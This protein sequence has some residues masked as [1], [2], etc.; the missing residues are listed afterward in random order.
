MSIDIEQIKTSIQHGFGVG[1]T[2]M[3]SLTL[4][5]LP[6]SVMMNRFIHHHWSLRLLMG[7]LGSTM[8]IFTI[9]YAL[10]YWRGQH[11]FGVY[12]LVNT[13][14]MDLPVLPESMWGWP[15]WMFT[16]M[17]ML[18]KFPLYAVSMGTTDVDK[19]AYRAAI[20]R[21]LL[22]PPDSK[23]IPTDFNTKIP[24]TVGRVHEDFFRIAREAGSHL[25]FGEWNNMMKLL[26]KSKVGEILFRGAAGAEILASKVKGLPSAPA[27]ASASA[28]PS[29]PA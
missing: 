22:P 23:Y 5:L 26:E 13:E 28:T 9:I 14:N 7:W 29:A 11:F 18:H 24:V 4:M 1:L 20:E 25:E 17:G 19:Q 16:W 3:V 10:I 8:W 6:A 27:S 12:P 2:L 15:A 21:T